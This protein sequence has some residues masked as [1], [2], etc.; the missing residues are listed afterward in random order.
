MFDSVS[1]SAAMS[2]F[3]TSERRQ[4]LRVLL[5]I[6]GV[7]G[8]SSLFTLIHPRLRRP[9][10]RRIRLAVTS[11]WYPALF[12]GVMVL[13]GGIGGVLCNAIISLGAL[14]EFQRLLPEA[15]RHPLL[16]T[17]ALL[18]VPL[19]Y[20][21]LLI[22]GPAA[23]SSTL[24]FFGAAALPALRIELRG[25]D[26]FLAASGRL[27]LGLLL[28]VFSLGF[29]SRI[30]LLRGTGAPAGA[31]GL[32]ALLCIGVMVSDAFQ[33]LS[34]KLFGRRA[35]APRLSPNKTREGF[36]GGAVITAAAL[37]LAGPALARIPALAGAVLG[38]CLCALGLCGDLLVSA[39]KRDAGVK[40]SGSLLP[41]QGGL[42]DRCDSLVLTAPVFYAVLP[43]LL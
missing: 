31:E 5:V 6:Y 21:A 39:I 22:V 34:G 41:G 29:L 24:L 32:V 28:C 12:G 30:L 26:G 3:L 19:Y 37:A 23:A 18:A 43:W 16:D 11:W 33:Y 8:F 40:D 7:I 17:L 15:D 42:L 20:G 14:R 13:C 25:H 1:L 36:M 9:E 4:L 10:A 27:L 35:L 38:L 2:S